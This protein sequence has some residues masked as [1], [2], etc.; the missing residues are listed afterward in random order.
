MP[1]AKAQ[2]GATAV[3]V[4]EVNPTSLQRFL[5][6]FA[7]FVRHMRPKPAFNSVTS[8]IFQ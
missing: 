4:N 1:L 8:P 3:F 2:S 6:F 7:R 5:Y